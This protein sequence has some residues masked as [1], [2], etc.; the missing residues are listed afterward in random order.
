MTD[1]RTEKTPIIVECL[2]E[3]G[4]GDI[5]RNGADL[6]SVIELIRENSLNNRS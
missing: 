6:D 3:M 5:I 4:Y 1:E 2:I